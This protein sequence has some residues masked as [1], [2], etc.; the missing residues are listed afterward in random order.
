M[1]VIKYRKIFYGLA[2]VMVG[3]SLWAIFNF[4]LNLG[5][6]FKG[7]SILEITYT[8]ERPDIDLI[9]S[10]LAKTSFSGAQVQP[11]SS[12]SLIVRL[13]Q[14]TEQQKIALTKILEF[15]G[16][17][18]LKV[19]RFSSIGPTISGE[20]AKR[21]LLAITLV[22]ILIVIFIAFVFRHVSE[23]VSSWKYGLIAL[24]AL[25]HDIII[26][27][28]IFA[29][30]GHYRGV[31]IDALYLTAILTILGISIH[32]TIVV[33][34]RIR[35]NLKNKVSPHFDQTVGLSL[36]QTFARSINTSLTV[37]IVLLAVYFFGGST[38]KNFALALTIGMAVGTY[39]S[40]FIA[41]PLLVTWNN[42]S[43]K[44]K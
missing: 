21:S 2:A 19:D 13:A 16:K 17:S 18:A 6:D 36:S 12:Q 31:E 30:L 33:F 23:P 26:P 37:V 40:I 3:F 5:I 22:V 28:G 41:S 38:T 25:L 4:G 15:G 35:E 20:L 9:K 44:R 1:F 7:G 24:I 8:G 10:E 29:A 39:S 43:Q 11:A 27:T 34:D 42:W 14:I 32:D